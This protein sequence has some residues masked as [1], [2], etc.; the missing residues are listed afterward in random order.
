MGAKNQIDAV[1]NC[2]PAVA[3]WQSTCKIMHVALGVGCTKPWP[4]EISIH[5]KKPREA[6]D[7]M[8]GKQKKHSKHQ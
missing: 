8:E 1:E 7:I 3:K 2:R 6:D 5:L 4:A